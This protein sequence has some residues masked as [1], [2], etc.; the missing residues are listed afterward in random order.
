MF[1]NAVL[2]TT[3]A[4]AHYIS[5]LIVGVVLRFYNPKND[6]KD[7]VSSSN[8]DKN[9]FYRAFSELYQARKKDGRSLG[10]LIGDSIKE[11]INTLLLVGGYIILFSV[12]TR[13]LAL[14]GFTKIITS[15]IV[16]ILKPFGFE[17]SLVLPLISGLFE[18]TN[19]SHLASQAVAP[20]SQKL[21]ITSGIIAW[22]GL[23]VH[24]QVATMINGT[25]LRMKPYIWARILHG[26]TASIITF[27]LFD[28]LEA[29][30]SNL[31]IPVTSN[32]EQFNY[33]IGYLSHFTKMSIGLFLAIGFLIFTSLTIYFIRK[34]QIVIFHHSK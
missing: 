28:P 32:I 26:I 34:I 4:L 17:Q 7:V 23:S 25:D 20:L 8:Q 3:L 31:I 24:A 6:N 9:I 16:F 19:G 5:C 18:I 27:F 10:Q 15:G 11:S 33:S 22:S 30:S 21:I 2:G 1:G 12:L 29:I 13:V 14:V